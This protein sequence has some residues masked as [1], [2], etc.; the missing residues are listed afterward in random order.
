MKPG[1]PLHRQ[2]GTYPAN[3]QPPDARHPDDPRSPLSTARAK[4]TPERKPNRET[5][6][7]RPLDT[8]GARDLLISRRPAS[9]LRGIRQASGQLTAKSGLR[10]P[11]T[12]DSAGW[13]ARSVAP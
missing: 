5:T 6:R 13:S 2:T 8:P 9:A 12:L 3:Q 10:V 7:P 4:D 1:R 11:G